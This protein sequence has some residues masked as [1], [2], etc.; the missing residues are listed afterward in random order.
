MTNTTILEWL[1]SGKTIL[2]DGA[3]GTMLHANGMSAGE[4]SEHWSV[5]HPDI[6]RSIHRDY[7]EAG[8]RVVTANTFGGTRSRLQHNGLQDQVEELNIAAVKIAREIA[9]EY[10]CLVG[11]DMG[12]TGELIEPYG[13]LSLGD[14]AKMYAEQATA[15]V[16]AGVDYFHIETMTQIAELEAA[17][18]G[19]REVEPDAVIIATM[20]FDTN[21]R[22]MM[23]DT[24]LGALQAMNEWG[25]RVIGGNCGN[26]PEEIR[27]VMAA[28]TQNRPDGVFLI[29]QSNAGLPKMVEDEVQFD[30]TPEV[31]AQYAIEMYEMGVNYIGACCGS[32]PAHIQAMRDT[33]KT[34]GA[35]L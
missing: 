28:M 13:L 10:D 17:I 35:K 9:D 19:A 8:A 25:V 6:L 31:M 14:A 3:M 2:G 29:A 1:E 5:N 33:L 24:P 16:N 7:C 20:T 15:L 21:G 30:G 34:A 18:R 4:S 12:P 26:G 32:T 11:G 23:G 22:T 27:S